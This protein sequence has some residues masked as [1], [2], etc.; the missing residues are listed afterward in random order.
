MIRNIRN[1]LMGSLML[2]EMAYFDS[3][4]SGAL[5]SHLTA[6]TDKARPPETLLLHSHLSSL[7]LPSLLPTYLLPSFPQSADAPSS[8]Y[9]FFS[10][11]FSSSLVSPN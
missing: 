2:Q 6:D 4:S 9:P 10:P 5:I 8:P 11:S 3:T 7:I 1:R